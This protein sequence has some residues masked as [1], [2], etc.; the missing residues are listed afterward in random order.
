MSDDY[1]THAEAVEVDGCPVCNRLD[2]ACPAD[3]F[4]PGDMHKAQPDDE[5]R[6]I[7]AQ[8]DYWEDMDREY[9]RQ[10]REQAYA[11]YLDRRAKCAGA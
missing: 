10:R 8:I 3:I 9:W 1:M 7:S 5:W 2:C 6:A 4:L 11:E